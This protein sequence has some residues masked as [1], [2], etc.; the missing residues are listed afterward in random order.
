M[1]DIKEDPRKNGP[2]VETHDSMFDEA[3]PPGENTYEEHRRAR[4]EQRQSVPSGRSW[5]QG[6]PSTFLWRV[7]TFFLI[8]VLL[9]AIVWGL[10]Q[11]FGAE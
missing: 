1:A 10:A 3:A 8:A 6:L 5:M 7:I 11:M 2:R 4:A 9:G